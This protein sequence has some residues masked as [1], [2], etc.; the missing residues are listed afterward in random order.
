MNR[1]SRSFSLTIL[2]KTSLKISCFFFFTFFCIMHVKEKLIYWMEWVV[3]ELCWEIK[4]AFFTPISRTLREIFGSRFFLKR[5]EDVIYLLVHH[6]SIHSFTE[7]FLTEIFIDVGIYNIAPWDFQFL[8]QKIIN[9]FLEKCLFHD[10]VFE[11]FF[12]HHS[13]IIRMKILSAGW[14]AGWGGEKPSSSNMKGNRGG[15][16]D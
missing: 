1:L 11:L 9:C 7:K 14:A 5:D 2:Q 15:Q 16:V 8:S 3:C 6:H 12:I 4:H 13:C 10:F